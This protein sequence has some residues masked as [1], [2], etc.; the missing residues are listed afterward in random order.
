MK[1]PNLAKKSPSL[2]KIP[3]NLIAVAHWYDIKHIL[4]KK[5]KIDASKLAGP[6]MEY[7]SMVHKLVKPT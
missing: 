2:V 7:M 5:T 3:A 6:T 4:W 1:N